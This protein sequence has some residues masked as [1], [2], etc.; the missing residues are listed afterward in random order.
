[1]TWY[2]FFNLRLYQFENFLK[3]KPRSNIKKKVTCKTDNRNRN[4]RQSCNDAQRHDKKN[5]QP[6][7]CCK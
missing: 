7:R 3:N 4:W 6:R 2:A 5:I 1:M